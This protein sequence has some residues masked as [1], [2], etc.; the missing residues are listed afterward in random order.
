MSDPGAKRMMWVSEEERRLLVQFRAARACAAKQPFDTEAAAMK[1]AIQKMMRIREKAPKLR[2]YRCPVC[3]KFH[4]TKL[5]PPRD[6]PP[7]R[8]PRV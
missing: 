5:Q 4:L 2:V 7:N 6:E 3:E 1:E 8:R